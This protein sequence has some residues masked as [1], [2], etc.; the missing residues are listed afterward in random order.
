[1]IR[2]RAL[3]KQSLYAAPSHLHHPNP[4]PPSTECPPPY[5]RRPF[6]GDCHCRT[7]AD[8]V[9]LGVPGEAGAGQA[10][11][12]SLVRTSPDILID[13]TELRLAEKPFASGGSGAI[14]RCELEWKPGQP[15]LVIMYTGP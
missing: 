14:Y 8:E 10:L 11:M 7:Q 3:D 12:T 6:D 5:P 13:K 4:P 9:S 15:A 1:V 2:D